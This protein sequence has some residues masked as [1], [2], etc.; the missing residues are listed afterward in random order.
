MTCQIALDFMFMYLFAYIKMVYIC[1]ICCICLL[2]IFAV[3]SLINK[4]FYG[5]H[6]CLSTASW[7]Q[8]NRSFYSY[9]E[10]EKVREPE[11]LGQRQIYESKRKIPTQLNHR[12]CQQH[13]TSWK[14]CFVIAQTFKAAHS[15]P[16]PP[17]THTH[18]HTNRRRVS[19]AVE[20]EH[21][22]KTSMAAIKKRFNGTLCLSRIHLCLHHSDASHEIKNQED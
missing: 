14:H 3:P 11:K 8:L 22:Q 6:A 18:T 21:K 15:R 12:P 10:S 17:L 7:L 19:V 5:W 4:C 2:F 1:Y 9:C 20:T 13:M 16:P